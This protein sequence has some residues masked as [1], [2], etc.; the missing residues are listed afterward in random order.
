MKRNRRRALAPAL[1]VAAFV[2][3]ACASS[4]EAYD[5]TGAMQDAVLT[6]ENQNF[7]DATVYAVWDAGIRDRL[8]MVTGLTSETFDVDVKGSELRLEVDF[9]AGGSFLSDPIYVGPGDHLQVRIPPS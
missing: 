6:A 2:G 5:D 9:V 4:P 8:G 3:G 1:V 7:L